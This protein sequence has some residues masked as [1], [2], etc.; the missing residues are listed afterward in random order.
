MW[1]PG[2]DGPHEVEY[3]K[4]V[5]FH[6]SVPG[7]HVE[8]SFQRRATG[9]N[10]FQRLVYIPGHSEG[11]GLYAERLAEEAG[12]IDTPHARLGCRGSQ[13]LRLAS[14]LIDIGTHT[15]IRPPSH[16]AEH[17][18]PQWSIDGATALA[19]AQGLTRETAS[20]WV[21]N[22]LGRPA[23]RASYAAGE[24][25]WLRARA[26]SATTAEAV[27]AFHA[28]ILSLG[29]LGLDQLNNEAAR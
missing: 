11:W 25:A 2:G 23:H 12:L 18:G 17:V 7:H 26:R 3:A 5:L 16:V 29:P 1:W 20:W 24:R 13:A 27:G 28:R 21:T 4:T 8:S 22:M 10:R 6:E 19:A 15:G 9:L 14:L